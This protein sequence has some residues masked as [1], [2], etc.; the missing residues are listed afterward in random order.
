[1]SPTRPI[2]FKQ[3]TATTDHIFGLDDDGNVY[4]REKPP[5]NYASTALTGAKKE[6]LEEKKLWRKCLMECKLEL[7]KGG[8]EREAQPG[9]DVENTESAVE[10]AVEIDE[11]HRRVYKDADTVKKVQTALKEKGFY[12]ENYKIDGDLANLTVTAIKA[13]QKSISLQET[14][15]I[16]LT[17]WDALGLNVSTEDETIV[18]LPEAELMPD[19]DDNTDDNTIGQDPDL[20]GAPNDVED[21]DYLAAGGFY[22]GTD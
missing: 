10:V 19:A 18:E 5:Y 13:F 12:K 17:L 11:A 14:G 7:P 21:N 1:M 8:A 22:L 3:I 2:S 20:F 4:Y 16:D 15:E 6:E 9:N